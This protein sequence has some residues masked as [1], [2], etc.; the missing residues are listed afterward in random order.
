MSLKIMADNNVDISAS[1][2]GALYNVAVNN[3]DF[4]IKGIGNEM[5]LSNNGLVVTVESGEAVLHGRHITA[6]TS[7]SITLPPNTTGF[8]CLRIDLSQTVGN[9]ALLY[10]TPT[11]TNEEINWN[12]TIYDFKLASFSTNNTA[13]TVL[14]D[15]RKVQNTSSSKAEMT[16][17]VLLASN[18]SGGKY[19][20]SDS[21]ISATST[22]EVIPALSDNITDPSLEALQVANIQDGGQTNGMMFL[23]AR[24]DVPTVDI[25]IRVIFKGEI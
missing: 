14:T 21:R 4:I 17:I 15:L 6:E 16:P 3:Q 22:Q 25:P 1:Q 9:E 7:N 19:T 10:A 23:V 24:G 2:D 11:V 5:S 13:V 18:W 8:L 12:G 20:I